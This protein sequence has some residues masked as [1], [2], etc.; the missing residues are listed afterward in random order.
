MN[1]WGNLKGQ[2]SLLICFIF[3]ACII[4]FL[5]TSENS[6]HFLA[7]LSQLCH[8]PRSTHKNRNWN[9]LD[10]FLSCTLVLQLWQRY[11]DSCNFFYLFAHLLL[12]YKTNISEKQWEAKLYSLVLTRIVLILYQFIKSVNY[13]LSPEPINSLSLSPEPISTFSFFLQML[14]KIDFNH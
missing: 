12:M 13:S 10:A 8:K 14:G 11:W 7:L 4:V 2:L 5:N 6:I 3:L 1:G 9:M